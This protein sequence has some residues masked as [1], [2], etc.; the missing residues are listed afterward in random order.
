MKRTMRFGN[1]YP[2]NEEEIKRY[3]PEV[4]DKK[5]AVGIVSP[6]AGWIYSG[7]TA[8]ITFASCDICETYVILCPSHTGLGSEIAVYPSGTWETPTGDL[9]IDYELAK[10]I[11]QNSKYAEF[12]DTAHAMEHSIE[13]QLPFIKA[14]NP[15]AKIVPLCL[16]AADYNKCAD[17]AQAIYKA[18]CSHTAKICVTASTDMSH[19]S[20]ASI[21][22]ICDDY[23]IK[24][25]MRLDGKSLLKVVE[26]KNISMCGVSPTASMLLYSKLAGAQKAE[27]LKYSNSGEITGD[28]SEVVGYA[29]MV[30]Y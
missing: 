6:H 18:S 24:E 29:G 9:E 8:G 3:I 17:L 15:K 28:F 23:A 14:V 5:N 2:N 22:K 11:V 25:I 10:L 16:I 12:D 20:N 21:A 30:I 7:K 26:E 13:V 19:Y 4:K 27:L 1:W